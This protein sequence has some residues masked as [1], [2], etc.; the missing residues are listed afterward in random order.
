MR[1]QHIPKILYIQSLFCVGKIKQY[2]YNFDNK[3]TSDKMYSLKKSHSYIVTI[4]SIQIY[5]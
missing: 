3:N 4:I 1:S 5:C 2:T